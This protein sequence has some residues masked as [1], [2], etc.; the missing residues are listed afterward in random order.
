MQAEIIPSQFRTESA[1]DEL[2]AYKRTITDFRELPMVITDAG[3]LMGVRGFG[4][5]DVGTTFA[6]DVLR[7][8]VMGQIGLHLTV[9]D[10]PGLIAVVNEQQTED[11]V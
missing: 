9:V 10:L 11:D 7:I 5:S 4:V 8:K 2:A 3:T 6:Q 1:K